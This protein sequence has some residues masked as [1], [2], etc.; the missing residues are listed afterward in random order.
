MLPFPLGNGSDVLG[1]LLTK[2]FFLK[3]VLNPSYHGGSTLCPVVCLDLLEHVPGL[4]IR[5]VL[6]LRRGQER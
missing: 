5:Q 6:L 4:E 3:S 1:T 2:K